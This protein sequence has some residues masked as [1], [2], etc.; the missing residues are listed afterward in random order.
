MLAIR[1]GP[2]TEITPD[3][4]R[5]S[6][7]LKKQGDA[8]KLAKECEAAIHKRLRAQTRRKIEQVEQMRL[9]QEVAGFFCADSSQG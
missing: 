9:L 5:S 6:P 2:V 4:M 3:D 8:L 1:L 7:K